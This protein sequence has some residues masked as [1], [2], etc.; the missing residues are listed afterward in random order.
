MNKKWLWMISFVGMGML[1]GCNANENKS[2]IIN[3]N[4]NEIISEAVSQNTE[5]VSEELPPVEKPYHEAYPELEPIK[6]YNAPSEPI[7]NTKLRT[8]LIN[9]DD[10]NYTI[11]KTQSARA[12]VSIGDI[13]N[14][15]A[16]ISLFGNSTV[17]CAKRPLKIKFEENQTLGDGGKKYYLVSNIYD[18]TLLHNYVTFDLAKYME[19]GFYVPSYEFVNVYATYDGQEKN[20]YQGVYLLAEKIQQKD[21]ASYN[22]KYVFEED[23]RVYY[24]DQEN[25]VEGLDWFWL[26]DNYIE[27]FS[28]KGD[29][30]PE[31]NAD[32]KDRLQT[33][34][35]VI[36]EKNW[37]AIQQCVDVEN[38]TKSF[39]LDEIIKDPDVGQTSVYWGIKTDGKLCI[40]S[41]WDNDLT[42]GSGEVGQA[43][44]D[45]VCIHNV[46]F[47]ALYAVPEFKEYYRAYFLEHCDDWQNRMNSTIDSVSSEYYDDL[48]NDYSYWESN[49]NWCNEEMQS[50]DYQEQIEYMKNWLDT[51]I[52]FLKNTL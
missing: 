41:I 30:S 28:V 44:T 34:W 48:F 27:C 42:F 46:L 10:A 38:I 4:G 33:I 2:E 11:S 8:L 47:D 5:E 22:L 52:R 43:D 15:G 19:G 24:D 14:V 50:L 36:K 13:T 7:E 6:L 37:E 49:Y 12:E 3:E 26:G 25:G 35:N 29:T 40:A 17:E 1:A 21:F 45:L 23:Y 51:R 32:I 18:K 9:F 20:G 31:I 16:Q 39:L